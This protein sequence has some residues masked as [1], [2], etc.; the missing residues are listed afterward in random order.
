MLLKSTLTSDAHKEVLKVDVA[1]LKTI[2]FRLA[3]GQLAWPNVDSMD[4][5]LHNTILA[6]GLIISLLRHTYLM[7]VASDTTLSL[8]LTFETCKN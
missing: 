4:V 3:L 6:L 5:G 7:P 1:G 2:V 8:V